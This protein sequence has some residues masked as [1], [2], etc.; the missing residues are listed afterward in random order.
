MGPTLSGTTFQIIVKEIFLISPAG[1]FDR[2]KEENIG[3]EKILLF[4]LL[5]FWRFLI[6]DNINFLERKGFF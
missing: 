1:L 6:F 2:N 3:I 4:F 5:S